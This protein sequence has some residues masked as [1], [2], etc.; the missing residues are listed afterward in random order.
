MSPVGRPKPGA[1]I[2]SDQGPLSSRN[3]YGRTHLSSWHRA[4]TSTRQT[5]IRTT[6]TR[7][8]TRFG[9]GNVHMTRVRFTV[10]SFRDTAK[11]QS[12]LVLEAKIRG[13][14]NGIPHGFCALVRFM[15]GYTCFRVD[16]WRTD[17]KRAR[18]HGWSSS[19]AVCVHRGDRTNRHRSSA[20]SLVL[21][22][23]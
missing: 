2:C 11:S 12:F 5:S 19:G 22:E 6:S 18:D 3:A 21:P 7:R 17:K 9:T 23:T 13:I 1:R 4:L 14:P 8:P 10:R 20:D 16:Y 15:H